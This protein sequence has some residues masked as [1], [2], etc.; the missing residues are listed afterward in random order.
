MKTQSESDRQDDIE[1]ELSGWWALGAFGVFV[2]GGAFLI[3]R[4]QGPEAVATLMQASLMLVFFVG[5]IL[6]GLLCMQALGASQRWDLS[7]EF[8][9]ENET[10]SLQPTVTQ[11]SQKRTARSRTAGSKTAAENDD[12]IDPFLEILKRN[13]PT[14]RAA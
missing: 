7:E 4:A 9:S 11:T 8:D 13:H 1:L 2:A 10:V 14:Q 6:L 12:E 3:A 5:G